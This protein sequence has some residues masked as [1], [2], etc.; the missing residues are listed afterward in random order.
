MGDEVRSR[1]LITGRGLQNRR[2]MESLPLRKNRE[3]GRILS[4]LGEGEGEQKRY[5]C[6]FI[7]ELE[8]LVLLR[9]GGGK[10]FP[11]FTRGDGHKIY[12]LVLRAWGKG[13]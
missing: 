7:W 4:M 11:L 10:R 1:S 13:T 8:V 3:N 12:N 9:R 5:L 2:G 6:S